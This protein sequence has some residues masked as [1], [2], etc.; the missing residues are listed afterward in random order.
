MKKH[1]IKVNNKLKDRG[2]VLLGEADVEK[3]KIQINVKAHKGNLASL[4]STVKHELMHVK[5]PKMTEKEVYKRTAQ[6]KISQPE[7]V[8]L[9][10]KLPIRA[11]NYKVGMVK[12]ML[13]MG[14][15]DFAPGALIEKAKAQKV[16]QNNAESDNSIS[17][18]EKVTIMGAM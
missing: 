17:R 9:L 10:A 5:H 11:L 7:Q 15:G 8:K 1:K 4:A 18:E 6:T 13:K 14:K 3:K 12:R 2:G 16:A